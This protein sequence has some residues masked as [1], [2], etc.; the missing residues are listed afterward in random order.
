MND[1]EDTQPDIVPSADHQN[2]GQSMVS[3][4]FYGQWKRCERS[5]CLMRDGG[6]EP[7]IH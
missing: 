2:T 7:Q 5:V 4:G 1:D 3:V 6:R